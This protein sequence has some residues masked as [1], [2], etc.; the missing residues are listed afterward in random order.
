MTVTKI[1]RKDVMALRAED[2]IEVAW[3]QM[4][5]QR[6]GELPVA[7]TT[8]R[9]V[10]MLTE[11]DLLVR[12]A[13]R[14]RPHWWTMMFDDK[15]RLAAD[16]V[17]VAGTTVGDLM[18]L[19]PT[20]IVPD[21]SI[22]TAAGLMRRHALG[23]LPVVANGVYLGLVIRADV[24]DHLSWPAAAVPGTVTDV[25]L[26]RLMHEAIQQELWISRHRVTVNALRGTIR[27]TGVVAGP[28][29]RSALIAMARTL[30]GCCGVEDRLVALPGAQRRQPVP[31][32]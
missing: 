28:A 11:H 9:L 26:E 5:G 23:A 29:E 6:L 8:G 10:G 18:T 3:R 30:P 19:A 17:R 31:V 14:P 27:L 15:D 7:D 22:E 13:P 24:L 16:Y 4:R 2:G 20:A 32:V 21:A 25:E 12:L 1:M